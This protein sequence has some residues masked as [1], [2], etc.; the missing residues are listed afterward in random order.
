M[1]QIQQP[2][3]QV[4]KLVAGATLSNGGFRSGIAFWKVPPD[5]SFVDPGA[6]TLGFPV[7]KQQL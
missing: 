1:A 5:F 6:R 2:A 4:V 7:E 3:A